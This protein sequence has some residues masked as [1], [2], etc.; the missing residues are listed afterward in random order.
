MGCHCN[1]IPK[2]RNDIRVLENGKRYIEDLIELDEDVDE[3][4]NS[5]ANLCETT[6]T[7]DNIEGLKSQEKNL[8]NILTEELSVLKKR[9][10]REIVEL[11]DEL[12]RLISADKDFHDHEHDDD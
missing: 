6:F 5:L 1:E 8:N 7:A 10:E 11:N 3:K 2:C 4:L 9:V 12:D